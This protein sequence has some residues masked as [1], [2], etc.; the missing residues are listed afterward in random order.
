MLPL[1][2]KQIRAATII[3]LVIIGCGVPKK[4]NKTG[5]RIAA[6]M[7]PREMKSQI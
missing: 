2:A 7:D 3:E 5:I 1:C 6:S 4:A